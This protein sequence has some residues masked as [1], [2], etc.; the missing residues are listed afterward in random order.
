MCSSDLNLLASEAGSAHAAYPHRIFEVGKVAVKDPADNYGSRTIDTLAF[1][2]ADRDAGFNEVDAHALAI[3]YYLSREPT[4]APADDPRFLPGRAAEIHVKGQRIGIM[5][6]VHPQVLANWGIEMP[7]AV[8][9]IA[10]DP[11]M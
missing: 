11:L 9:E 10:L 8:A 3:F 5:G 6:E 1:L 7:C 2:L 4:F